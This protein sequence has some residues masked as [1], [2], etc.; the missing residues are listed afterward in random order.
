MP[1]INGQSIQQHALGAREKRQAE[2]AK[3]AARHAE[4]LAAVQHAR[5]VEL[6][7]GLYGDDWSELEPQLGDF[8]DRV[9]IDDIRFGL[10]GDYKI[11]DRVQYTR[12][13]A[14]M[15]NPRTGERERILADT[16]ADVG[17]LVARVKRL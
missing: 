5:L 6:L 9:T 4:Q 12:L 2:E 8:T 7:A 11:I 10:R 3:T 1:T 17:E 15:M 14:V 16:L 13:E